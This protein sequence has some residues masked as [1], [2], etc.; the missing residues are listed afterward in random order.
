MLYLVG[1]RRAGQRGIRWPARR[2]IA[3]FALGLGSYAVVSFG[4]LGAYSASLRWAFVLRASLL[5]LVVPTLGALGS[6]TALLRSALDEAPR[7]RI[8]AILASRVMRLLGNAIVAPIVPLVLFACFLTPIAGLLR[9]DPV[10][11]ALVTIV[12]PVLGL[13]MAVALTDE[14]AQ[15]T[16]QFYTAEF[17]VTFVELL[18]DSVPGILLRLST[19]VLDG[20]P[21]VPGLTPH[22][23]P[24]PLRD[25]QLAGDLLWF[26]AEVGDLPALVLLFTRWSHSDRREARAYDD[27]T[28]EEYADLAERHLRG[29]GPDR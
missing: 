28:D 12:L 19:T 9:T 3:F 10:G 14:H 6:P 2:T 21:A 29:P 11:E 18:F 13:V 5:L 17:L 16:S 25:Q 26:M 24:D 27:L 4:F 1:V 8:D 20:V 7:R 22:W 15:R 23:F